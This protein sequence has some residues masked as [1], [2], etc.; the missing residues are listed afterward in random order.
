MSKVLA[1]FCCIILLV[2]CDK[3][4]TTTQASS[5]KETTHASDN[6]KTTQGV[7][8]KILEKVQS[9]L[10]P[11][12]KEFAKLIMKAAAEE[13]K[14]EEEAKKERASRP[15][16]TKLC[17]LT[18][19]DK[20]PNAKAPQKTN[21][22]EHKY[23]FTPTKQFMV[24]TEYFSYLSPNSKTLYRIEMVARFDSFEAVRTNFD[25][26]IAVLTSYYK[27]KPEFDMFGRGKKFEFS[28]GTIRLRSSDSFDGGYIRLDAEIDEY[29]KLS[30]AEWDSKA[31]QQAD[32]SALE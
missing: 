13:A 32:T 26:V 24:F 10:E 18:F 14:R 5:E 12:D 1:I 30:E 9:E 28:N 22:R 4:K 27:I 16:L 25:N 19:G 29:R 8:D 2:A 3:D 21:T 11:T 17:G 20:F 15:A 7:D 31:V 23:T 6:K